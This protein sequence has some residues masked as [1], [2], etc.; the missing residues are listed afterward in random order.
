MGGDMAD[1][2]IENAMDEELLGTEV[3][4]APQV[5]CKF[6]GEKE[7]LWGETP[8]G[9]RLFNSKGEVHSCSRFKNIKG[10]LK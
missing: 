9:W 4:E 2:I 8:A 5:T 1:C 6:C 7:L 3:V 10:V